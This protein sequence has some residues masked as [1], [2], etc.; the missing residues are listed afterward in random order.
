MTKDEIKKIRIY[1]RLNNID[2]TLEVIKYLE[3]KATFDSIKI[4]FEISESDE[5]LIEDSAMAAI[6]RLGDK[7]LEYI[8][9]SKTN[10][11]SVMRKFRYIKQCLTPVNTN[12]NKENLKKEI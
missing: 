3:K 8:G 10:N 2:I 7:T 6:L 1:V 9:N 5:W 12:K 4:L 11:E